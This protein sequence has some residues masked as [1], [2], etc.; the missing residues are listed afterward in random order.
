MPA[1][2]LEM[3]A[4]CLEF[5]DEARDPPVRRI[6]GRRGAATIELIVENDRPLPGHCRGIEEVPVRAARPAM[7]HDDRRP[8]T[9]KITVDPHIDPPARHRHHRFAIGLDAHPRQLRP[10]FSQDRHGKC[11]RGPGKNRAAAHHASRANVE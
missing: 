1:L 5:I 6:I 9:V 11:R 7:E 3:R 10:G 2:D 8:R 4:D